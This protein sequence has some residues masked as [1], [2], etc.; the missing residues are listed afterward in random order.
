MLSVPQPED[1]YPVLEGMGGV[2]GNS[3]LQ[4]QYSEDLGMFKDSLKIACLRLFSQYIFPFSN[5]L[6]VFPSLYDGFIEK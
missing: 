5:H 4:Y 3:I 2:G 1:V 6:K